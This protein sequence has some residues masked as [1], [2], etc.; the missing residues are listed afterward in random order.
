MSGER[1]WLRFDS[2]HAARGEQDDAVMP[3]HTADALNRVTG[4]I[5][6]A[7]IKV[8]RALGP[9]LLESAYM[10]CLDFEIRD[11]SLRTQVQKTIPLVTAGWRCTAP[12]ALT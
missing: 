10:A 3:P 12:T 1:F 8:H 5:V 11:A 2:A 7:A 6:A 4:I 9:G